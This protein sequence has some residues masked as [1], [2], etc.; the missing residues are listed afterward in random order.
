MFRNLSQ[1]APHNTAALDLRRG[2]DRKYDKLPACHKT[3]KRQ[4]GS[5][6]YFFLLNQKYIVAERLVEFRFFNFVFGKERALRHFQALR[7]IESN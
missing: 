5:L 7:E 2:L 4:A 6:P 3:I 1:T